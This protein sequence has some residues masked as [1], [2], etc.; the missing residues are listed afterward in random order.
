MKSHDDMER[1]RCRAWSIG[2]CDG[3]ISREHLISGCL[4]DDES[5]S[6]RGFRW[7]LEE[8]KTVGLSR[9]VAKILSRKHSSDLSGLD[10]A[11]LDTFNAFRQSVRLN[12]V[13]TGLRAKSLRNQRFV[14]DGPRLERWFLR[15]LIN[16][17]AG[18]EWIV[19]PGVHP[20]G[21]PSEHLVKVAFGLEHATTRNT[22][23]IATL[24][25]IIPQL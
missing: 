22:A 17:S 4:F 1:T 20:E 21:I 3:G 14:I 16:L 15:T 8:P 5:V 25:N 19:G 7:C 18:S 2:D 13:R 9:L 23:T 6:V 24:F 11:A 12:Q 10:A